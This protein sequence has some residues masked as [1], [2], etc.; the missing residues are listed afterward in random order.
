[1][2]KHR[3]NSFEGEGDKI[4]KN[5]FKINNENLSASEVA[6]MIKDKFNL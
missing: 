3:L 2:T 4:F 1:M 6:T 5:Y